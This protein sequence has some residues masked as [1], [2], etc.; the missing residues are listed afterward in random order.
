MELM[1]PK[2]VSSGPN[3]LMNLFDPV[4]WTKYYMLVHYYVIHFPVSCP[5][6]SQNSQAVT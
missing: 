4:L 5:N 6:V 3:D 2:F 1:W